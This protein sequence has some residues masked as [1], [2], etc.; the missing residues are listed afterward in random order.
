MKS[1]RDLIS[2]IRYEL[3]LWP[4]TFG[5]CQRCK[6]KSAR[7]GGVCLDCRTEELAEL[8]G[9]EL[10]DAYSQA[11]RRENEIARE[12]YEAELKRADDV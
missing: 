4:A 7:G 8:V 1:A 12:V 9:R 11:V 6:D 10:A 2:A 3:P 5:P